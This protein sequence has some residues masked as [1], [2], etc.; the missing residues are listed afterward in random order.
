MSNLRVLAR[1]FVFAMTQRRPKFTRRVLAGTSRRAQSDLARAQANALWRA[2]A[3]P[4]KSRGFADPLVFWL[5]NATGTPRLRNCASNPFPVW[6]STPGCPRLRDTMSKTK[7]LRHLVGEGRLHYTNDAGAPVWEL[8]LDVDNKLGDS[9]E[10]IGLARRINQSSLRGRG[11]IEQSRGGR[12]AHLRFRFDRRGLSVSEAVQVLQAFEDQL[13]RRH[14]KVAGHLEL[15]AIKGLPPRVEDNEE[16]D[17]VYAADLASG[18]EHFHDQAW[19]RSRWGRTNAEHYERYLRWYPTHGFV[20]VPELERT[21]RYFS[22]NGRG[23]HCSAPVACYPAADEGENTINHR[24]SRYLSWHQTT[25]P[26]CAADLAASRG[27]PDAR[28]LIEPSAISASGAA[29]E[30]PFDKV[31]ARMK[32][33]IEAEETF[34]RAFTGVAIDHHVSSS[35]FAM[36]SS[37]VKHRSMLGCAFAAMHQCSGRAAVNDVLHL[38]AKWGPATGDETAARVAR[39]KSALRLA[40]LLY[41]PTRS[42]SA[43]INALQKQ[44]EASPVHFTEACIERV[45][46]ELCR[47]HGEAWCTGAKPRLYAIVYLTVRKNVVLHL[48]G[49]SPKVVRE[50][51]ADRRSDMAAAKLPLP[52]QAGADVPAL[53][54]RKMLRYFGH[55]DNGKVTATITRKLM[56]AGYIV[57]VR[58]HEHPHHYVDEDGRLR[59]IHGRAAQ[60]VL[61]RELMP[62]VPSS[63][64]VCGHS[65]REESNTTSRVTCVIITFGDYDHGSDVEHERVLAELASE[66][67]ERGGTA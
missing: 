9:T 57:R 50:W 51:Q 1:R 49:R 45:R 4:R 3:G 28:R 22:W 58:E 21:R 18:V 23:N 7:F 17:P 33:E 41:N 61:G 19:V 32:R 5:E 11:F 6:P 48:T 55:T 37:S 30:T 52:P 14:Q 25:Q 67:V 56:E 40:R 24:V 60:Y 29:G 46:R 34:E 10:A 35:L 47:R 15:D 16:F 63:V 42:G 38:Y 8:V 27:L 44:V 31:W 13:K 2:Y 12:G 26:M 65:Y 66:M 64:P 53:A 62:E 54:L 20:A 39:A 43:A 59:K 36:I